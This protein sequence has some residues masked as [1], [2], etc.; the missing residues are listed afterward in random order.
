[1]PGNPVGG[2]PKRSTFFEEPCRLGTNLDIGDLFWRLAHPPDPAAPG[3][4]WA[5]SQPANIVNF[6]EAK[7]G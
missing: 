2:E 1:M 4:G 7:H 6:G 3:A 5:S